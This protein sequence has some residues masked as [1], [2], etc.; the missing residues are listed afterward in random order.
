MSLISVKTP[1]SFKKI[2]RAQCSSCLRNPKREIT[3]WQK[4][5]SLWLWTGGDLSNG[6]NQKLL[7]GKGKPSDISKFKDDLGDNLYYYNSGM[8]RFV[9]AKIDEITHSREYKPE[10]WQRNPKGLS[11][12]KI[13][14]SGVVSSSARSTR[15]AASTCWCSFESA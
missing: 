7:K 1:K 9:L 15:Y 6:L 12:W 8:A 10:L 14:L 4:P 13:Q 2:C 5:D 3:F 11:N